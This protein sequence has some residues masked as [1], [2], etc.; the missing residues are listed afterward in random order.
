MRSLGNCQSVH[1][2]VRRSVRAHARKL[3]LSGMFPDACQ[4][5][6]E[7]ELYAAFLPRNDK[8]DPTRASYRTFVERAVGN[9]AATLVEA[10]QAKKRGRHVETIIFSQ[11]P[12]ETEDGEVLDAEDVVETHRLRNGLAPSVEHNAMIVA[13]VRRA[14]SALPPPLRETC[15]C[16]VAGTIS[17]AA[18][19]IGVS[20]WTIHRRITAIKERFAALG[21]D[22]HFGRTQQFCIGSGK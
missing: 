7:Q 5:D 20:R 10:A 4:R 9:C 2:Y 8:Y 22:A 15:F 1:P 16:L 11:L 6:L 3:F 18:T 21:L 17:D 14:V 13:D 19:T 12:L